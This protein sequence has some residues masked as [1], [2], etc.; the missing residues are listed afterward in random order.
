MELTFTK[1]RA[2]GDNRKANPESPYHTAKQR[3][4]LV[5]EERRE[6]NDKENC[7]GNKPARRNV[8]QLFRKGS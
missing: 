1:E 4:D 2:C 3:D 7:K 5:T 6:G 8:A